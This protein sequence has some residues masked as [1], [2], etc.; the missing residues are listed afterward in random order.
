MMPFPFGRR[1]T[2]SGACGGVMPVVALT[3]A[4]AAQAGWEP[5]GIGA[6]TVVAGCGV[7]VVFA[8]LARRLPPDMHLRP[9]DGVGRQD[10]AGPP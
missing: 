6:G 4:M 5:A 7:L 9:V 2:A 8:G 1:D 10:A 3:A